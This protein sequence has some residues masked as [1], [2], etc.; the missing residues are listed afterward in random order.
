MNC[1]KPALNLATE[2]GD[3]PSQIVK[4]LYSQAHTALA[5]VNPYNDD[6]W[7]LS[8]D[9]VKGRLCLLS[10]RLNQ[11]PGAKAGMASLI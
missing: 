2:S 4:D 11:L 7:T 3:A 8:Y 9:W 6:G 1:N 5:V 10:F